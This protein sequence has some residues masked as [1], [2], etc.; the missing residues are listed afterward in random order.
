MRSSS[1]RHACAVEASGRWF[2]AEFCRSMTSA[3]SCELRLRASAC[4]LS[5]STSRFWR[6]LTFCT[7]AASCAAA[8]RRAASSSCSRRCC[9]SC[10]CRSRISHC[11]AGTPSNRRAGD[12]AA[13]PEKS[14]VVQ[15]GV[16]SVPPLCQPLWSPAVGNLNSQARPGWLLRK[17]PCPWAAQGRWGARGRRARR[18]A[19]ATAR[20]G[21]RRRSLRPSSP[22][23]RSAPSPSSRSSAHR[24]D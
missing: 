21:T 19:P 17:A 10:R 3:S 13:D 4:I 18:G 15:M 1:C 7:R 9:R 20:R 6:F 8:R 24:C 12:A 23:A 2:I 11:P 5:R 22:R 14:M 16:K